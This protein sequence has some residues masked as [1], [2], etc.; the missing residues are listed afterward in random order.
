MKIG[1]VTELLT[2]AR[3]DPALIGTALL[4]ADT[5]EEKIAAADL[6]GAKPGDRVLILTGKA[7]ARLSM[8]TPADAAA[9]VILAQK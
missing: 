9:V 6:V 2:P 1:T 7:A 8:E 5:G 4:L 3:Q